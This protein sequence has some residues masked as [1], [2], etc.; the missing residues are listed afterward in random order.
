MVKRS[1]LQSTESPSRRIWPRIAP[2]DSA[3]HCQ[4][5]STN[6]SRPRSCRDRPSRGELALDDVLGGDAGVVHAGQ[7][8]RL[9]ALHPLAPDQRVLHGV[10]EGVADVQRAGDVRRRDDDGE[11]RLVARRVGR[12]V[13]GG[14]P[15]LVPPLLYLARLVLGGQGRW[16]RVRWVSGVSVTRRSLRSPRPG[17]TCTTT[18]WATV[19]GMSDANLSS[20]TRPPSR[21]RS[22]SRRRPFDSAAGPFG[23][24]DEP[25]D[26]RGRGRSPR[27]DRADR[28]RSGCSLVGV[29]GAAV[30][31]ALGWRIVVAEGRRR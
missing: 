28:A 24:D 10:V 20:A 30:L 31:G 11:R 15:L 5:R 9:E 29:A 8:Q 22:T 26:D 4:T 14:Y 17:P 2:P 19:A 18:G 1:R 12:E 25:D 16:R 13:A 27:A 21:R 3:F 6:F 7:P 23:L